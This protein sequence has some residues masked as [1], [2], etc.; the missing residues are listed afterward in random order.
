MNEPVRLGDLCERV[1][2]GH[3]G[4][5]SGQYVDGDGVI[6]LRS[7]DVRPFRITS[8]SAKR[9]SPEFAKQL[10]K[11]ELHAGDVVVVRTGYPGTAAVVPAELEGANCAD[12]VVI[13]PRT[14]LNAHVLAALFNSRFGQRLVGGRLVGAAQQHFNVTAAKELEV[15]LPPASDQAAIGRVVADLCDM[16]ENNRRRIAILEQIARLMYREW[17]VLFRFPG[18]E[19]VELVDSD[20]GPLPEGWTV[21]TFGD[22]VE[23]RR[24]A[25]NP[26]EIKVGAVLVGLEHLPRRSTTLH[27]WDLAAV[28]GSRKS[29]FAEGDILF[30]KI[31]PYFHKVVLAPV[32]GYCSMDA[33]VFRPRPG[34]R[35]HALAVASSDEFVA[36]AVQTSNGTKMPRANTDVLL[37]YP[38]AMPPSDVLE[39]F[40]SVVNPMNSLCQHL[41]AQLR[42]L[43]RARD[44]LL[45]RLMS[46]ELDV[47]DLDLDLEPVT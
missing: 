35:G 32:G 22:L 30:G 37:R 31:R 19:D 33:I 8:D 9:V 17:F 39:H 38:I 3:V 5:M 11:S 43:G 1:T 27:E 2:V 46:G 42:V 20:L 18:H 34:A 41:A 45:P 36:Y 7:Q 16:I 26:D 44:I 47:S 23:L 28:A 4:K 24:E 6:F 25:A 29:L 12:L 15:T 14:E 13:T 10:A 21:G 40:E